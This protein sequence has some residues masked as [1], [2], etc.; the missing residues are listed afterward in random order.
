M[1][2][3]VLAMD[4]LRAVR[5]MRAVWALV[6]ALILLDPSTGE[7]LGPGEGSEEWR[8]RLTRAMSRRPDEEEGTQE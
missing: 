6:Q 8:R 3:E 4:V 1:A 5:R 2:G 7:V